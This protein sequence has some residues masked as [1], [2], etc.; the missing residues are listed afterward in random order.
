MSRISSEL[1]STFGKGPAQTSI[2]VAKTKA[3]RPGAELT[4][5]LVARHDEDSQIDK[6]AELLREATYRKN[7]NYQHK[8]TRSDRML[9]G[10]VSE[11]FE[12]S[13]FV[14]LSPSSPMFE[15]SVKPVLSNNPNAPMMPF[16]F[17]RIIS[18][19]NSPAKKLKYQ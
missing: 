19:G 13:S 3:L 15:G 7:G 16:A 14:M 2:S 6:V 8:T 1:G 17:M 10:P 5:Q 11:Q 12:R 18:S 9:S 4:C